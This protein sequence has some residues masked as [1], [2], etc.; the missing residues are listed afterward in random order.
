MDL[1]EILRHGFDE[2]AKYVNPMIA[3]RAKLA[4]EPIR[5]PR[6]EGGRLIDAD[7]Q[8]FEDFHG[9]QLFGHRH[10]AV[11]KAVIEYL[12]TEAPNWYPSRVSPH[13]GRLAK[14]LCERTGYDDVWFGGSGSDAVEATM[15][16]SRAWSKKPRILGLEKAYH[17]CSY[18]STALMAKGP[19]RDPFGPHLPGVEQLPFGDVDAL[20]KALAAGD[21]G[22]V[23]VEPIQGEG[24]VR[25]LPPAYVGALC[26][27][28]AKH[29]AL[30]IADEVQTGLGRTGRGFL[31]SSTWPR[32]P[33]VVLL[34]KAVGGGLAPLSVLLTRMEI[35][36]KAY[37]GDF[38][39][40]ES[41]N[42]TFSY[43]S[44]SA[45]AG[46]AAMELLDDALLARVRDVGARFKKTLEK[47]FAGNPLYKG[48]VRGE[49]LMLGIP[50]HQPDHP[51]LSF[52]HFGFQDLAREGRE[53]ISAL[54]C[55]RLF[56]HG[57][58]CFT[59]GHDWSVFRLQPRY[60]VAEET[61]ERFARVA[62]QEL[63]HLAELAS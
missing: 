26:E 53:T 18:G 9:T 42:M 21:V 31:A 47:A 20:A 55:H 45:V 35:F 58:F 37:G 44:L 39:D 15:K 28:T 38:E 14:M 32:K 3:Q 46:I 11:T 33:D 25:I 41:H 56:Q 54:L 5:I 22:S 1:K 51:W 29:G 50:L 27:L 16:L 43:N 6:C 57:F 7:G 12:Q 24:G 49:G 61:L 10:P 23:I 2:Y 34:A 63:D 60:E 30:L 8:A 17:G 40:G 36:Q 62:R 52:E 48:E 13:S 59:C 19:F 4:G